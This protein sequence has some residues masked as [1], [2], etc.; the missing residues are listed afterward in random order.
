MG[1]L[2]WEGGCCGEKVWVGALW[3]WGQSA[4]SRM[5]GEPCVSM[6]MEPGRSGLAGMGRGGP[7][8]LPILGGGS[9]PTLGVW[10]L[11]A[12]GCDVASGCLHLQLWGVPGTAASQPSWMGLQ[13]SPFPG[14]RRAEGWRQLCHGRP[15]PGG[16]RQDCWRG[17]RKSPWLGV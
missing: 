8:L 14:A 11:Q 4:S 16:T 2:S 3:G 17:G 5:W 6:V 9:W 13:V 12:C 1:L 7:L 10:G 15:R